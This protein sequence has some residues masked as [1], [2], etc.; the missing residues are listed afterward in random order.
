MA[1][2][3]LVPEWGLLR[4][5]DESA[6]VLFRAGKERDGWFASDDLLQQVDT[7]I[8]VFEGCTKGF[9]TALFLFDNAPSHQK[10]AP[11]ALSARKL[12]KNPHPTWRQNKDG[13]KMRTTTFMLGNQ[14]TS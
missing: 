14:L 10:R 2:E 13:P 4:D 9:A 5:G 7:A 1:S 3:F 8:D 6:R 12:P 11:D